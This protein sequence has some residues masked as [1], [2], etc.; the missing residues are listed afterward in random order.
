MIDAAAAKPNRPAR[1]NQAKGT[2]DVLSTGV[3]VE[4]ADA[5]KPRG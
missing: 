4:M 2:A 5:R 1:Y 3:T